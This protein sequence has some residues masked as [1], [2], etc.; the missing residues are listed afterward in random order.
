MKPRVACCR[1]ALEKGIG[2]IVNRPFRRGALVDALR[3][4]PIPG[5]ARELGA[6]SWAQMLLKF[7]LAHP[8]ITCVIPATTREDHVRENKRAA[9]G[10]LPDARMQQQLVEQFAQL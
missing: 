10:P 9:L 1:L 2:V 3:N 4:E 5:L 8:A 7:V 6:T